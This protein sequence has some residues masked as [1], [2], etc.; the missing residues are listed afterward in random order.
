MIFKLQIYERYIRSHEDPEHII[1]K[2]N[3]KNQNSSYL[4]CKNGN[5]NVPSSLSHSYN[6][7]H[8]LIQKDSTVSCEK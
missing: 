5:L 3:S 4:A 6:I 1:N 2:L 7:F 8:L